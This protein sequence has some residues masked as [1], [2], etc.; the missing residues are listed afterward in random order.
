MAKPSDTFI[1]GGLAL[2]R[3]GRTLFAAGTWGHAVAI[4]PVDN[5]EN[6]HTIALEKESYP[7]GCT[8]DSRNHFLYVSLW[9]AA[10]VAVVGLEERKVVATW[11]TERHPTELALRADGKALYVACA[12]STKVSVIDPTTGK[13]L[14]TIACSLYPQAP[15]GNTPNSL[16]LTPD[17]A[18]LFVANADANNLAVFNV[19]DRANAKSLGF[20]TFTCTL[21]VARTHA[22]PP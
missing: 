14:Q 20:T 2:D 6:R 17:G 18:M 15:N 7:Y 4:V 22:S 3:A 11:P 12:N 1:V 9:N 8:V 5:P 19:T 13:P 21:T 10:A 16:A